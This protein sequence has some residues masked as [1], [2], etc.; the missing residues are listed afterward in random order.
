M[1]VLVGL[2]F[3]PNQ[4]LQRGLKLHAINATTGEGIWNITG[5]LAPD[6]VADGYLAASNSYDGYMYVFG[7]GKRQ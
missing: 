4:P 1:I 5:C 2:R 6:A 3:S 7:N